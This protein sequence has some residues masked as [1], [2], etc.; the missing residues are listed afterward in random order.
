LTLAII[1]LKA[2][3]AIKEVEDSIIVVISSFIYSTEETT[4][5]IHVDLI[6]ELIK[7]K[8]LTKQLSNQQVSYSPSSHETNE[9][10]IEEISSA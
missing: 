5:M 4:K 8:E 2:L 6:N 1:G 10:S 7:G 9:S 3:D